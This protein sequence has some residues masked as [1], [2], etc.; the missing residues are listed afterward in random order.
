MH[1]DNKLG[2]IRVIAFLTIATALYELLPSLGSM[3]WFFAELFRGVYPTEYMPLWLIPMTI[4]MYSVWCLKLLAGYGLLQHLSWGRFVALSALS[5]D[6]L[7]KLWGAVN[8]WT[9]YLRHPAPPPIPTEGMHVEHISAWPSY[10]IG[11]VSLVSL[12]L[13]LQRRMKDRFS[14][15]KIS[16]T[17]ESNA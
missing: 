8:M 16:E 13:L 15:S 2:I 17:V 9:Y 3:R 5:L 14:Q 11:M 12:I 1:K 6:F 7:F 10:I 4:L